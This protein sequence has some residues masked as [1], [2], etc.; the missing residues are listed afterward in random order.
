MRKKI[1]CFS[2]VFAFI[3]GILPVYA[4]A[5]DSVSNDKA[6]IKTDH[7]KDGYIQAAYLGKEEKKIKL[8]IEKGQSKYTYDLN[9][10][11]D[12]E[13]FT[14]QMGNGD[15]KVKVLQNISGTKYAVIWTADIKAEG[16]TEFA[17]FLVSNQFVHYSSD[18]EV[19]KKATTLSKDAKDDL[20]KVSNIYNFVVD[21]MDYDSNK[22]KT[23]QSGY[24][25][26]ID[27]VVKAKKGICFDY[28]AV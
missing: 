10:K 23:V 25:P 22:A 8:T 15:Y 16:I 12:Y 26:N 27:A 17:P 3:F 21:A 18:N 9:N 2:L 13:T 7:I 5:A 20:T 19:I 24:L 4:V 14:L 11:G 28:A 1:L 6:A